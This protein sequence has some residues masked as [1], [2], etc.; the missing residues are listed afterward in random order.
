MVFLVINYLA[1]SSPIQQNDW[2]KNDNF[3]I[4]SEKDIIIEFFESPWI[5]MDS[6]HTWFS[7]QISYVC[8]GTDSYCRIGITTRHP[9]LQRD[10]V[11]KLLLICN[12]E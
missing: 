8:T 5:A 11:V 7:G 4:W 1:E 2:A 6:L 3:R 9:T 12:L 10:L